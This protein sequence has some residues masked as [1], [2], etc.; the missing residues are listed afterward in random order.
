M[1]IK[2][3]AI[4]AFIAVAILAGADD[5][6]IRNSHFTKFIQSENFVKIPLGWLYQREYDNHTFDFSGKD[7]ADITIE[8]SANGQVLLMQNELPLNGGKYALSYELKSTNKAKI[9]IYCEWTYLEKGKVKYKSSGGKPFTA[10]S[11]WA[12]RIV[13]FTCS[14]IPQKAY[15][16]VIASNGAKFGLRNISLKVARAPKKTIG[17]NWLLSKKSGLLDGPDG[18][19]TL[20]VKA[21]RKLPTLKGVLLKKGCKYRLSFS[22]KGEGEAGSITGFHT[23]R[24]MVA[25]PDSHLKTVMPWDDTWASFQHKTFLFN[26]PPGIGEGEAEFSF[27]TKT[28]GRVVFKNFSLSTLKST[29]ADLCELKMTTPAYRDSIYSSMPVP[30]IKGRIKAPKDAKKIAITLNCGKNVLRTSEITSDTGMFDFNIPAVDLKIGDYI[31]RAVVYDAAGKKIADLERRIKKLPPA[32]FEVVQA[33]NRYFHINGKPFFPFM[34]W[35][36]VGCGEDGLYYAARH[37]VNTILGHG[38]NEFEIISL[39]DVADKYGIR[40]VLR[41]LYAKRVDDEHFI[42]WKTK[43]RKKLSMKVRSHPALLGY[44]LVDE[45][46]W[47]GVPVKNLKLSYE[48][49]KKLDP[50]HPVL[51]NGAPRGAVSVHRAYSEPADI[52][53]IDIYPVPYPNG[54]SGLEDKGLTS[55]GKYT[56]MVCEAT[57]DRKAVWMA[58][59]GFSWGEMHN[60]SDKGDRKVVYP[61]LQETR[62]MGYDSILNGG[63]GLGYWGLQCVRSVKFYDSLFAFGKEMHDMARLFVEGRRT[64]SIKPDNGMVCAT[65]LY[66]ENQYIVAMNP[67]DKNVNAKLTGAF[68]SKTLVAFADN[69]SIDVSSGSISLEFKPFDVQV[70]GSVKLPPPLL[71]LPE[72]NSKFEKAGNP[73]QT[74]V[75]KTKK[76]E[77][78]LSRYLGKA[79]WIWEKNLSFIPNSK[80]WLVRKF[81][82]KNLVK[83]ARI[84][85]VADD[86]ATVWVNGKLVGES[87]GSWRLMIE[88]DCLKFLKKGENLITVLAEDKGIL[89]CGVL[90]ELNII[91]ANGNKT[92]IVSDRRWKAAA[93]KPEG[94]PSAANTSDMG[95]AVIVAPY[96]GGAW[97]GKV[98]FKPLK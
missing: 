48:V 6:L 40:V 61:T 41:T 97:G 22:V 72:K 12:K 15:L 43:L 95:D 38:S 5:N 31:I 60:L 26:A 78:L 65:Y 23:Y 2:R 4:V 66:K 59:Q 94:W 91:T 14:T 85:M 64:D 36:L 75:E 86:V 32:P 1:M 69:R 44:F 33:S 10:P 67:T 62:F 20:W 83:Q 89:P 9:Q 13:N 55:V 50:Y 68:N 45:A 88:K 73:F 53:G 24:V 57:D 29:I 70:Y 71:K 81:K 84:R 37:G 54:H 30:V 21:S 25:F 87:S 49:L 3:L 76:E 7:G 18:G 8:A 98:N 11:K 56:R 27:Q 52:Y 19:S 47:G 17:G 58:L 42:V 46:A 35:K 90:V 28:K 79:A 93:K 39:L 77:S 51:S 63:T 96:G 74:W 82:L 80:V 16:A 34:F 92:T